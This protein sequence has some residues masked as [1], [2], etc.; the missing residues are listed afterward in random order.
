MSSSR[1][2]KLSAED[3]R[4]WDLPFVEE[5][6]DV[7]ESK[8]NAF[9]RRSDWKY[10][11][12]E[13]DEEVLPPTAEEIE[14]IRASAY[15]EGYEEGKQAGLQA[16]HAE[17]LEQGRQEGTEQGLEEGRNEGLAQAQEDIERQRQ[18]WEALI[19]ELHKPVVLAQK[20]A[21]R[22]LVL[23]AVSLAKAVIRREVE[24]QPDVIQTALEEAI[25]TLPINDQS[26]HI[27][28]HPDDIAYIEEQFGAEAIAER[29]WHLV[30]SPDMS[31][32]GCDI[33]T[34]NNAVD[35]SIER[36]SKAVL[37]TFLVQQGLTD[38]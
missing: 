5:E 1:L 32:G 10:E 6:L 19:N 35:H 31:R 2:H 37:D 15:Q 23:L 7:D 8:T 11:P 4:S 27:R 3:A 14:Q 36:R 12:P 29:H 17:G 38:G 9:N 16:G 26:I 22:Q 30:S 18:T 25:K 20:E 13:E 33:S 21:Q 28:M 24:T 34:Q